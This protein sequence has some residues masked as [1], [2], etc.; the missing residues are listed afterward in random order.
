VA[1]T[2]TTFVLIAVGGLVRA[3]GSGLGCPGWP[4]CFGRW[5]PPLEYH[6]LIEFTHRLLASV[7]LA[8]IALLAVVAWRRRHLVP[9]VFRAAAVALGVVLVQAGLGAVVVEGELAATLVTA[10]FVTAMVLAAVLVY[11]TVASYAGEWPRGTAGPL[12][13]FAVVTAAATFVLMIIGAYVRGQGA[14][15]EF[16]DWPLMEGRVV[17]ALRS[18]DAVLHFSHRAAALAVGALVVL[19]AVRAWRLRTT[20]RPVALLAAAAA[21]LF[22]A[23]VLVGAANVWTGLAPAAVVAHVTL[24]ALTWGAVVA[25][26]VAA[27]VVPHRSAEEGAR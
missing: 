7:D 19:L 25:T 22:G 13:E 9:R 2:A 5:I 27:R 3:T 12:S 21:A 26:A 14:G 1:A 11:A 15:L 20:R 23:Q 16:R 8:L 6:A 24:S 18:V 17:P 10:H 4:R